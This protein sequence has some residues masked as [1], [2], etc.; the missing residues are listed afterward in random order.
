MCP[1]P[2]DLAMAPVKLSVCTSSC[3]GAAG[4]SR[5]VTCRCA[6][7]SCKHFGAR[8]GLSAETVRDMA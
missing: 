2:A 1:L 4:K 7:C 5:T 6:P 8:S 3:K